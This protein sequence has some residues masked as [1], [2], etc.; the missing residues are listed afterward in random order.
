VFEKSSSRFVLSGPFVGLFFAPAFDKTTQKRYDD[1]MGGRMGGLYRASA[2]VAPV[3]GRRPAIYNLN[4]SE[5]YFCVV[6]FVE[7]SSTKNTTQNI[8]LDT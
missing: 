6:F 2:K 7:R 5:K 1:T 8:R 4:L 3:G